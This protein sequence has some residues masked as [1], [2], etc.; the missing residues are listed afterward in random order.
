MLLGGVSTIFAWLA[1]GLVDVV[2]AQR[3]CAVDMQPLVHTRHV[4]GVPARQL[5]HLIALC[6]R[7][8]EGDGEGWD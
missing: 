4:E 2:L 3:T 6:H 8:S 5:S 7:W 1:P